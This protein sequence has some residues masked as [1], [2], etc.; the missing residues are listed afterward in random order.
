MTIF[1]DPRRIFSCDE[2]AMYLVPKGNKASACCRD[3]NVYLKNRIGKCGGVCHPNLRHWSH[4]KFLTLLGN[5]LLGAQLSNNMTAITRR[6]VST[7]R[8]D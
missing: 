1:E 5:G 2:R 8:H 3:K 7:N 6:T 4:V